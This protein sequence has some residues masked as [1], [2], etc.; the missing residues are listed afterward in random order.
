MNDLEILIKTRELLST[1]EKW[2]KG[3]YGCRDFGSGEFS[4][5]C[6]YGAISEAYVNPMMTERPYAYRVLLRVIQEEYPHLVRS[7]FISIPEFNDHPDTTYSDVIG[8]LDKAV[9]ELVGSV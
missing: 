9:S 8:V 3:T 4:C 5:L 2:H 1:P 7:G 6:L